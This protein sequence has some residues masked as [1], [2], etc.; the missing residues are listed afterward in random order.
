M[1]RRRKPH[2]P[3]L[4]QRQANERAE[5]EAEIKRLINMGATVTADP[6]RRIISAYRSNVFNLLLDR[7]TITQNQYFAA[8]TLSKDWA[9]WKGL[10]GRSDSAGEFVDGGTGCGELVT[11]RMLRAGKEVNRALTQLEP[12]DRRLIEACMVATVE[13][14]R[15]MAWRALVQ[16]IRG[17]KL[18]K[19]GE[20]AVFVRA[21]ESLRCVYEAPR[22]RRAA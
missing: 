18:G 11:D 12:I 8:Y 19:P 20:V 2:D 3:A 15:P 16:R 7:G 14:D 22:E 4:I 5:R 10:D 17:D 9:A 6:A 21:L 13:E 1:A